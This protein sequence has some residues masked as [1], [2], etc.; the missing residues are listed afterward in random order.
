MISETFRKTF[1][2]LD[3]RARD[4]CLTFEKYQ[5]SNQNVLMDLAHFCR[6]NESTFHPNN[7]IA[8]RLDGRRE[9][10]LRIQQHL[11]LSPEQLMQLY[12]GNPAALNT[13]K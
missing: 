11:N 7:L 4:Y 10:W 1:S 8:A 12:A 13:E 6:A 9:V 2:F 5:P 3:Q